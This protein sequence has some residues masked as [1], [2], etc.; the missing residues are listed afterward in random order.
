MSVE[1]H[2]NYADGLVLDHVHARPR[3]DFLQSAAEAGEE[4]AHVG[5]LA[6]RC[7]LLVVGLQPAST[8]S[9]ASKTV[10]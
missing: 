3:Q 1:P 10:E 5:I 2:R 4:H 7:F 8:C 6:E 9:Y